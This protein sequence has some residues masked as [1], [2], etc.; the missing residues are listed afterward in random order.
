MCANFQEKRTILFFRPN[1][2]K[3]EFWGRNF[4]QIRNQLF[5]DTRCANFLT[6]RTAL[7]FSVQISPKMNLELEIQKN[8]VRIGDTVIT[9]TSWRY[10]VCQFLGKT[11]NFDFFRY[12]GS[13]ILAQS[14]KWA[15]LKWVELCGGGWSWVQVG[16]RFNNTQEHSIH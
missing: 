1:L 16:V 8:N 12:F 10:H 14:L 2:P 15:G 6:K 7:T 3:N 4:V 13:Y 11:N 5:Q 9:E